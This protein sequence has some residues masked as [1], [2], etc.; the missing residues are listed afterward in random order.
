[1]QP[2]QPRY[3]RIGHVHAFGRVLAIQR[4]L[5]TRVRRSR[6]KFPWLIRSRMAGNFRYGMRVSVDACHIGAEG[7]LFCNRHSQ[8]MPNGFTCLAA[9]KPTYFEIRRRATCEGK[10]ITKMT[11]A[12]NLLWVSKCLF[13]LVSCLPNSSASIIHFSSYLLLCVAIAL[14]RSV[15]CM[16]THPR[17]RLT[18]R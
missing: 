11:T 15:S 7:Y 3:V 17:A 1:M 12:Q 9:C 16:L 8:A 5:A 4:I 13:Q 2:S 10:D 6:Q 14:A 18:F